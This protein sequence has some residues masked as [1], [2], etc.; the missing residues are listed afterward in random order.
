MCRV[1]QRKLK[2]IEF[3]LMRIDHKLDQLASAEKTI[4]PSV[5]IPKPRKELPDP[6]PQ[7]GLPKIGSWSDL[8]NNGK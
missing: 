3:V 4:P 5:A 6:T 2:L 8:P 1:I 7:Q